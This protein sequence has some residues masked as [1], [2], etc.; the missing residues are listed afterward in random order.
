MEPARVFVVR[1]GTDESATGHRMC[2]RAFEFL[3][4]W[5]SLRRMSRKRP[6]MTED[7]YV[8]FGPSCMREGD[9]IVV[10]GSASLPY[11]I[12]RVEGNSKRFLMLGECYCDGIMDGEIVGERE[13]QKLSFV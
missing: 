9:F 6:F 4:D 5:R 1:R 8:G 2:V 11:V 13:E 12:R 3:R 10:L 7:R